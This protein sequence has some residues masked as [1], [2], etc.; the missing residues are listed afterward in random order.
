MN[1]KIYVTGEG[2]VDPESDLFPYRCSE[3]T[4]TA[5]V[6]FTPRYCPDH[7]SVDEHAAA[8]EGLIQYYMQ[9]P[10]GNIGNWEWANRK[11]EF[12]K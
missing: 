12:T 3:P 5:V 2:Y 10:F 11:V 9:Y 1:N 8:I 7:W 6:G 4:C